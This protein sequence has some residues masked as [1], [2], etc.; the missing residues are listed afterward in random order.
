MSLF[1]SLV[2]LLFALS[3]GATVLADTSPRADSHG[4]IGV[5]GDHMHKKR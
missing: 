1:R 4:P 2:V 3:F 5:M